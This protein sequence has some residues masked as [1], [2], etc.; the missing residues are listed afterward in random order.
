MENVICKINSNYQGGKYKDLEG[1]IVSL[2]QNSKRMSVQV[3]SELLSDV[4]FDSV[5]LPIP[6]R[7]DKIKI[8]SGDQSVGFTGTL[9]GMD[10]SDCIVKLDDGK[11]KICLVL[12]QHLRIYERAA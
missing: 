11:N 10:E 5:S 1:M 9:V 3:G 12:L 6:Q 4:P 2:D 7:N 8:V